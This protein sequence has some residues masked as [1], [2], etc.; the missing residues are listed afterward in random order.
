MKSYS[1]PVL[2][3]EEII[4]INEPVAMGDSWLGSDCWS[5]SCTAILD[6]NGSY[7]IVRSADGNSA[8]ITVQVNLEH[9]ADNFGGCD[10][11]HAYE[12]GNA[13]IQQHRLLHRQL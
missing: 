10:G 2:Y 4:D 13:R 12:S 7:N 5:G 3:T 6:D 9:D 11:H 8:R 1:K